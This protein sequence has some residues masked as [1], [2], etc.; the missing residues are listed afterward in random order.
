M[1]EENRHYSDWTKNWALADP[2]GVEKIAFA[3]TL[4]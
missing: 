4:G 3:P 2:L 1:Q